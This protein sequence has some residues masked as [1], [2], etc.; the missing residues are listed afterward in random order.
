MQN[1]KKKLLFILLKPYQA[2]VQ[3]NVP[4][5]CPLKTSENRRFSDVFIAYKNETLASDRL[6]GKVQNE[7]RSEHSSHYNT[8]MA[9]VIP[10]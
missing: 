3:A 8:N 4:F 1:K 6:I 2:N 10:S 7:E 9:T 5:L